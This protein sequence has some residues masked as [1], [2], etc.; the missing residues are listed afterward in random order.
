MPQK[1]APIMTKNIT[2]RRLAFAATLMLALSSLSFAATAG[3]H[4]T[5]SG[6]VLKVD[7]KERTLLLTDQ[8]TKKLYLVSVPEGA[9]FKVTFGQ[10]MN[11][12]QSEF[13]DANKNDRV[14]ILCERHDKEHLAKLADGGEAIVL[15]VAR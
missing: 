3:S 7:K 6:R 4:I 14:R 13:G 5:I 12:S 15:T 2:R 10:N 8:R 1:G 9:T 11:M